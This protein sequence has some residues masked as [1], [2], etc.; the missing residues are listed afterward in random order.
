MHG[1]PP[2]V[3]GKG[4]K[5]PPPPMS[6]GKGHGPPISSAASSWGKGGY[7]ALAPPP[8]NKGDGKGKVTQTAMVVAEAWA[9]P[10]RTAR[11]APP[12]Q[13]GNLVNLLQYCKFR[14]SI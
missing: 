6:H 5:G 8:S 12:K 3:P 11:A 13:R 10:P 7:G 1:A 14:G 2:P 4:G 9:P